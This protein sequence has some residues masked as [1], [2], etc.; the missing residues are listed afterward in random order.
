[1]SFYEATNLFKAA[2]GHANSTR[3]PLTW[4]MLN[5]LIKLSESLQHLDSTVDAVDKTAD[6][7]Q[8]AVRRLKT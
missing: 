3:D 8:V 1:M 7:I 4:N 2:L 5:G 6:R